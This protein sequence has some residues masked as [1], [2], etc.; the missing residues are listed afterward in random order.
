[1]DYFRTRRARND[2]TLTV[3]QTHL[4]LTDRTALTKTAPKSSSRLILDAQTELRGGRYVIIEVLGS[5]GEGVVYRAQDTV[6]GEEIAI[7]VLHLDDG[8]AIPQLKREF[9]FLRDLVHPN[10]LPLYELVVERQLSF[11]TMSYIQGEDFLSSVKAGQPLSS[12]AYQLADV[13]DFLHRT[14][15]V[16]RDVK[17]SNILVRPNGELVLMDFGIGLDLNG[18]RT[19]RQGVMGT[20]RYMAPEVLAMRGAG[21]KSDAY[22]L[23]VLLYE[24]L[25]G[26]HPQASGRTQ[27]NQASGFDPRGMVE[28]VSESWASLVQGLTEP[29]PER[30]FSVEMCLKFLQDSRNST[31]FSTLAPAGGFAFAGRTSE[32]ARLQ[33]AKEWVRDGFSPFVVRVEARSGMGKTS[34]VRHFLSSQTDTIVLKGRCSEHELLPHKAIDGVVTDLVDY[35]RTRP[36]EFQLELLPEADAAILTQLFPEF[37]LLPAYHRLSTE[38]LQYGDYRVMRQRAYLAL[39]GVLSRLSIEQ[40]L[41]VAIDD[42]QWGDLDSGKLISEVFGGSDRPNCLLILSYRSEERGHSECLAEIFDRKPGLGD[43]VP[44]TIIEL[45]PLASVDANLLLQEIV[46]PDQRDS[47]EQI[48]TEAKGSPLLLTEMAAHVRGAGGLVTTGATTEIM[49]SIVATRVDLLSES[50]R[51]AFYLL[52]CCGGRTDVT[53]LSELSRCS[54]ELLVRQLEQARLATTRQG[55]MWI[56][57]LHDAVRESTLL[58]LREGTPALHLRL[59]EALVRRAGD[60]A[61]ITRHFHACHD[62]R[63]SEWAERA[64]DAAARSF[65]LATSISLYRLALDTALGERERDISLRNRLADMLADAGR[66]AEAAPIYAQLANEV[67]VD[68]AIE[69]RRRAAEQWLITGD[70]QRGTEVLSEVHRQ[71]GLRWPQTPVGALGALMYHRGR[72]ALIGDTG[73]RNAVLS[74]SDRTLR[75]SKDDPPV[76]ALHQNVE[77]QLAAC[78]AAWPIGMISV[79]HGAANASLFLRLALRSGNPSA[80]SIGCAMEAIYHA[81]GGPKNAHKVDRWMKYAETIGRAH[82]DSYTRAFLS[83]AAGQNRYLSGDMHAALAAFEESERLFLKHGRG[84]AWE[85]NSGRIFWSDAL[86]YLGHHRQLD[87][88]FTEWIAD[89]TER[90]D[91]HILAALQMAKGP[92][93][94]LRDGDVEQARQEIAEGAARWNAPYISYHHLSAGV[95]NAYVNIYRGA[96]REALATMPGLRAMMKKSYMDQV[97]VAQVQVGGMEAIASIEAAADERNPSQRKEHLR[98]ARRMAQMMFSQGATWSTGLALQFDALA[99]LIEAPSTEGIEQLRQA[100]VLFEDA[101]MRLHAA[102]VNGRIGELIGGD[103]GKELLDRCHA[104]FAQAEIGDWV[105]G[106]SCITPRVLPR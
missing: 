18:S 3:T 101:G 89:A 5:G 31:R 6:R 10:L 103:E 63:T 100:Q 37:S 76:S 105:S 75:S 78:R 39:A 22:S 57:P 92:R 20:P 98:R 64:A 68:K 9:R 71:V 48:V 95:G 87:Q 12:L 58:D 47:V 51:D 84:V 34:L 4:D 17:P 11:F 50:S 7:K 61:E 13:L 41:I 83:F 94:V 42:L 23:G 15:R 66:G 86:F 45:G 74:Q 8:V 69:L 35:L 85:L 72:L 104:V 79:I 30:R 99:G 93:T 91:D 90:G 88:R 28:D 16:H 96:P 56:E 55:G 70:S 102:G 97:H 21:P 32:L 54:G 19:E 44:G 52:C 40:S 82:L 46:G 49:R 29:N 25:T 36:D 24:A 38:V 80:L 2:D 81:I 43:D 65:A 27:L 33:A 67:P 14:G 106:L 77:R 73:I 26:Q 53:L 62:P 60:P 1:M 59:A